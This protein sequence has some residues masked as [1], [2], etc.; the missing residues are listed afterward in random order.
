[1]RLACYYVYILSNKNNTVIYTGVT[2]NLTRRC[3]EH[4]SKLIKGFTEKYN[5]GKLI[6]FESF[7][8]VHTAIARE[9]QMKS[10]SRKKKEAIINNLNPEWKELY[11]NGEINFPN[12]NSLSK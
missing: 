10:F 9:K 7:N 6:Y 5:V 8:Q 1:M 4:K 3:F 12:E 11:C 2:N